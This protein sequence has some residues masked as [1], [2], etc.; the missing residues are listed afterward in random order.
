MDD[1][2]KTKKELLKE[3]QELRKQQIE[4]SYTNS[5]LLFQG[6]FTQNPL[7]MWIY[8][9]S[10]H[11]VLEVN[12]IACSQYGYSR[13]EFLE[14]TIFDLCPASAK[15]RL[16]QRIKKSFSEQGTTTGWQ[17]K[18]KNGELIE[19]DIISFEVKFL[20]KKAAIVIVDNITQQINDTKI[21][22]QQRLEL[23]KSEKI[24]RLITSTASDAIVMMNSKGEVTL[25]NKTA[26]K[27]FGFK[28]E[29]ILNKDLH[30][31]IAPQRYHQAMQKGFHHFLQ[32]GKGPLIN[33]TTE[34]IGLHKNGTEFPIEISIS[35]F[36]INNKWNASGIIRDVSENRKLEKQLRAAN[37]KI[38]TI[39]ENSYDVAIIATDKEGIITLFNVGA[40]KML[41]YTSNELIG[42]YPVGKIHLQSEIAQ[43]GK[44][45]SAKLGRKIEGFGVFVELSQD[46]SREKGEWTYLKKNGEQL[47]MS[48]RVTPVYNDDK[49]VTGYVGFAHDITGQYLIEKE[50][51][52]ERQKLSAMLNSAPDAAI[53]INKK[54][55]IVF[56]NKGTTRLLGYSEEELIGKSFK[57]LILDKSKKAHKKNVL[58]YFKEPRFREMG[59]EFTINA[60]HK[61]GK[62]IPVEITLSPVKTRNDVLVFSMLRDITERRI[63]EKK[64]EES[65]FK[66]AQ[67]F[68]F[69]PIGIAIN[70]MDGSFTQVNVEFTRFT[71]YTAEELNK[72]TY[73][74]LT[75]DK[76]KKEEAVQLKKLET[77][78]AY[79]PY[80]KE[81][82]AKDGTLV[83]VLLRGMIIESEGKEY[84]WSV[85]EDLT[86]RKRKEAESSRIAKELRQFIETANA[87]I[88]GIDA[89]GLV[90]EWNQTAE[91]ITS[92]KKDE[93][94]GEDLVETY[95]TEDYRKAVKEVLDNALKGKET[96]NYEFPLF[97][98]DGKRVMVLLNSSTRRNAEGQIVGVLGVGQDISEMDKLRTESESVA[99][100][101][102]Q[103]IETANAPIFGIDSKGLVNEWN[104]TAEKIT[105]FKKDEVLGEDLV[106]T[107]ITEDYRKAVKEV[108]DNALKGKETANYEFP[109]FTKDGKRVMVLLN[110]S[111]RRNAE[112]Q[113]VG[114]LGVGQDIS[115]M[116]KLRT[117][118]E[119]VAKELRQFI[120]TANAPIFGI[121]SKGLV[122]EWNQTAEKITSFKKDEVLGEDLVETYITED[123]RKAVKEVLD[124]ALKGKETANYEFPL[125]T[126]DG[127]R[128]MVLL[129]SSTRRNAEGQIVGVLGVGQDISIL[130][131]YKEN[132]ESKV[133]YRTLE[134]EESLER[135]KEL[136]KLKTSFVSMASHEFR[137]P[138]TSIN[139]TSDIILR[140]F[141][142]LSR[143][144]INKR[145]EKIKGE[146]SDMTIM[147]E[148]ILIIG[149]SESQKLDYNPSHMDIVGT[150]KNIISEYQLSES[151]SRNII[152]NIPSSE[153]IIQADKKW[154]KHIIINLFSNAIKY[155]DN[156]KQID[157]AIEKDETALRFS[158]KDYG[159]GISEEDIKRLF[160]PFHRGKNVG[161][162]SGTGLGLSILQKA[163]ELHKGRIEVNSEIGKG[164]IFTV[165]LPNN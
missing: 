122:N 64:L 5:E 3:L 86:E 54:S 101:L 43:R 112:G 65:E 102:R 88:F 6:I 72:L 13:E 163:I 150:I 129:N 93:V 160:E 41:G 140:Y 126:K 95:I 90:N 75:P 63:A 48:L 148:D 47:K 117:E 23:A 19:V 26:E 161:N 145:L 83:P 39:F 60:K 17:H 123:Y 24:N 111:T 50:R 10:T 130:N 42:K 96:A 18:A 147:L 133:K 77:I 35:S 34:V 124:N 158:F 127:K 9:L 141:D 29:E 36:Q 61:S 20:E 164:S 143:E 100:E 103:F 7:P 137:T 114:V 12:P 91:K 28:S 59:T 107:Y 142:K 138:L 155:S 49:M 92:F 97:T 134:L 46:N 108:L 80:E 118:S 1:S 78:R 74:E 110:S 57:K 144:D 53:I 152:Y 139:A 157:I 151:A 136:G 44:E 40:E 4:S 38:K 119:S 45:L 120:E 115:E 94:L 21:L 105:S 27:M 31:F 128:V 58:N 22:A 156:S 84:I 8:D 37:S 82:I 159:I 33:N 131:E 106:E 162:I 149:K 76:Y 69:A 51:E 79:G 104:Q 71:G 67:F 30:S 32:S 2:N 109:L 66:L 16:R 81:Y 153:I 85:V 55:E 116:D 25:W 135:E 87:P 56:V 113:I 70:D 62:E 98:K 121:D 165:F 154:I 125:F 14:L 132:L 146:V 73:W 11:Q 89:H 52:E 68:N 99:K 15:T